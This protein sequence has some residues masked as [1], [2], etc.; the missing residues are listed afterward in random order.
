[1][2]NIVIAVLLLIGA[3]ILAPAG[4]AVAGESGGCEFGVYKALQAKK[5]VK[6]R[7]HVCGH[8]QG[9]QAGR[10]D[11]R[12]RA[13]HAGFLPSGQRD[14]P[15]QSQAHRKQHLIRHT[16]GEPPR[17]RKRRGFFVATACPAAGRRYAPFTCPGRPIAR[18]ALRAHERPKACA[19]LT[20]RRHGG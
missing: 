7:G 11:F 4:I 9:R 3:A 19:T 1:M 18:H 16:A 14:Q 6:E 10:Q 20:D 5:S 17:L 12:S 2:K 15:R 8:G 13:C